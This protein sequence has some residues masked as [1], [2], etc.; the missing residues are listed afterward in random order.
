VFLSDSEAAKILYFLKCKNGTYTDLGTNETEVK[1]K[2]SR[3]Y[4]RCL[5]D[6]RL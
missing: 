1:E 6:S 3:S 2:F 4:K 5:K